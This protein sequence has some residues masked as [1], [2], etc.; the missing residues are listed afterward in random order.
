M[1]QGRL[2]L[3]S[4][5]VVLVLAACGKKPPPSA[6][7]AS[8][9]A[10]TAEA[11][12]RLATEPDGV[13]IEYRVSGKGDPAIVLI[14]G[15]ATDANYWNAQIAPLQA[16]YTVVAVDLAGHGGSTKS[17]NVWTMEKYGE[18]VATVVQL[19]PNQKVILVGHSMGGTVALEAAHTLGNRVIGIIVVDALKSVGLPPV[20]A[21]EIQTRVAPFRTDFIG[22][23]RKYVT[24]EL[25]E[26]GADPLFVQ[27]V[28]YDMSLEPPEVAVPSLEALLS[29][30]FNTVLPDIQV[31]VF[32]I[33]SDLGATDEARIRKSL[34][35]FK[36][37][38]IPHTSHFLMMEVPDKFNPVLMRD[39]ETI[40]NTGP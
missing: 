14:H 40:V 20:P 25:F 37:D 5:L 13:H 30:D 4:L 39:I 9:A 15:W 27:K 38:V 8:S 18:D 24:A 35:T 16:K 7:P 36:S 34:P 21:A 22:S 32:A 1:S 12:T 10:S 11:S 29:M 17:R 26:K 31:P 33:N 28:A 3:S 2:I 6:P 23:V 19:I